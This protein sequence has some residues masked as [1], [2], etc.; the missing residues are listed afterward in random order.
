VREAYTPVSSVALSLTDYYVFLGVH[1]SATQ[2]EIGDAYLNK[3]VQVEGKDAELAERALATL[4][5]PAKRQVYDIH[6]AES[7]ADAIGSCCPPKR[8]KTSDVA[9][10]VNATPTR[11]TPVPLKN[12]KGQGDNNPARFTRTRH[13]PPAMQRGRR[14][15]PISWVGVV[16]AVITIALTGTWWLGTVTA[17]Q[18]NSSAGQRSVPALSLAQ[19]VAGYSHNPDNLSEQ[20]IRSLEA[21]S[22]AP[23][24]GA[25]GKQTVNLAVS[26]DDR[27][28]TPV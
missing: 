13:S 2:S 25:D 24:V 12:K 3:L 10:R 8:N 6:L 15:A 19:P 7:Q 1:Q 27:G 14:E 11:Q 17:S 23:T 22:T 18:R 28:Y 4:T 9:T 16:A 20:Q 21:I 26:G 5:N